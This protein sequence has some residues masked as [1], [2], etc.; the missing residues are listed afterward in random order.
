VV[1][2]TRIFTPAISLEVKT[3]F[4]GWFIYR[5]SFYDTQ[6]RVLHNNSA[7]F[8]TTLTATKTNHIL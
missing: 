1:N 6:G 2:C 7:V 5:I 4:P 3:F 8:Y